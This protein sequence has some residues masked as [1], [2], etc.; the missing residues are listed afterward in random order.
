MKAPTP[1]ALKS[2]PAIPV[3]ADKIV[4]RQS[5]LGDLAMCPERARQSMLGLSENTSSTS[6]AIGTAV[7]AGIEDC[8]QNVIDS[9]EPLSR[10]ATIAASMPNGDANRG[11]IAR[12]NHKVD[13]CVEIIDLNSAVW[14]DEVRPGL[15]PVAVERTFEIPID[16]DSQPEVW[17][18]GTIDLVEA[19]RLIDWKNPGRKPSAEWEKKRWSVQAAAYTYAHTQL[20]GGQ[21]DS[22]PFEF[23]HLVK[24]KVHRTVVE[25]GAA[26][27]ASLVALARSAATL[28]AADLPVWP[29]NMTGWHCSPKWCGAWSTCRG[30]HAGPDPWDQL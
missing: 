8:L 26:E 13:D 16:T 17:L 5:W 4:L 30:Q 6:T 14:W 20:E 22:Y 27:W 12:G 24:G 7:H 29:L 9:G 3:T 28:V 18:Q 1:V 21:W 19:T 23:V 11:D 10:D 15:R 2:K 25:V